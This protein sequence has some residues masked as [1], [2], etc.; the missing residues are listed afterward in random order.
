MASP[1]IYLPHG[2]GPLPLLGE[3]NH[4]GLIEFI[5]QLG[6][7][8]PQP[9]SIIVVSAHWEEETVSVSSHLT[10]PMIYDYYGFSPESYQIEYS[11]PGNYELALN[12]VDKLKRFGINAKTDDKR[13][14]DHGTFVPLKL[15]FPQANIPVVQLSLN[16]DLNPES[17]IQLGECIAELANQNILIIGSGMSFHNLNVLMSNDPKVLQKSQQFDD[18][19]NVSVLSKELDWQQKQL[20][21]INWQEAP[22][23]RFAHPREEHLMPL[24]VCFGAAKKLGFKAK[25]IFNQI[26]LNTRVS[27]FMW[28]SDQPI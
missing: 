12:I 21:L 19:L 1:I 6:A 10:P 22:H 13:G 15:L 8:V 16:S 18:W 9:D 17:Q 2:G 5:K 23:A 25:S 26:F 11:A 3:S 28:H 27:G 20:R 24:H 4:K 7:K 14:F